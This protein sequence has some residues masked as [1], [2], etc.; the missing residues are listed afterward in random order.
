MHCLIPSNR[1]DNALP[2]PLEECLERQ[3]E[4]EVETEVETAFE[5]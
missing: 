3:V 5:T 1:H 2:Y 4:T